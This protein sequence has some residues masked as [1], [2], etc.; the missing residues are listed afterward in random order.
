MNTPVPETVKVLMHRV[1][2]PKQLY[3][4]A[5]SFGFG[6]ALR[7]DRAF[8]SEIRAAVYRRGKAKESRADIWMVTSVPLDPAV[9]DDIPHDD[10][11]GAVVLS[12]TRR[13][14]EVLE[15]RCAGGSLNE[16]AHRMFLEPNT[17][18][19]HLTHVYKKFGIKRKRA[20]YHYGSE[21]CYRLGRFDERTGRPDRG[22]VSGPV[23]ADA[24]PLPV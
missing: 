21:L 19:N 15:E 2:P 11:F 6:G 13:E 17:V 22:R 9:G 20:G 4:V 5:Q 12:L 18:K 10:P 8:F 1:D 16:V 14:R 7:L 24:E 3:I 23:G